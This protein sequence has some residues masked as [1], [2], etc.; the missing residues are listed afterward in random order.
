MDCHLVVTS[1]MWEEEGSKCT[2]DKSI[3]T[4][5]FNSKEGNVVEEERERGNTAVTGAS[6]NLKME[7]R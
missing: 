5:G 7:L 1:G 2:F 4:D 3:L 6:L